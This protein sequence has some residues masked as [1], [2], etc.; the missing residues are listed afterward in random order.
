MGGIWSNELFKC[1][2]LQNTVIQK[3]SDGNAHTNY[4]MY[5]LHHKKVSVTN[6]VASC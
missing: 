2:K 6:V 5:K 3:K 1:Y 4:N